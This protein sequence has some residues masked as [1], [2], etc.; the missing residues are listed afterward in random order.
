MKKY[1]LWLL[2]IFSVNVY[3]ATEKDM[4][5]KSISGDYDTQRDLA[6]SYSTGWGKQ[7]DNDYVPLNPV[8]ACAWRKVIILTNTSKI[9]DSDYNNES[10][11][12]KKVPSNAN[13][14]VWK[15]VFAVLQETHNK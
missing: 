11:D 12:C 2:C 8:Y 14:T 7:G 15:V 6:Y 5:S 3:S 10:I 13:G 4:I 9:G 1:L